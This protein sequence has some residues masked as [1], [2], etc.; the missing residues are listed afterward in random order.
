GAFNLVTLAE[1]A[2]GLPL[3]ADVEVGEFRLVGAGAIGQAAAHTLALAGARGRMVVVDPEKVALSNLQR[4]VF[5]R[6]SDIGAVKVE[7][8]RE[9]LARSGIEVVSTAAE[10]EAD[11]VEGQR[12]TLVALDSPEARLGVQA[13]L[14]GP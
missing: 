9:R 12:P 3:G 1:P 4:Y 5:T 13:S 14:P 2:Y 8:L 10:W 7:L 11:L 6:D